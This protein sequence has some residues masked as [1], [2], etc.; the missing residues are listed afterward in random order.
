LENADVISLHIPLT[1]ETLGFIDASFIRRCK[2]NIYLINTSRGKIV[3]TKDLIQEVESG[4]V[5]G[6]CLDVLGNEK[7]LNYSVEEQALYKRLFDFQNVL[8]SPHIAGWTYESKRKIAEV[9]LSKLL[10]F[11]S[12]SEI[13]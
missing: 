6:A 2:K 8:L 13:L 1:K 9:T 5:S 12:V 11:M 4:K 3:N 7:P 10:E